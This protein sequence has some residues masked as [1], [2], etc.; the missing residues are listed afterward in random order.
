MN[1][2]FRLRSLLLNDNNFRIGLGGI[3]FAE[4]LVGVPLLCYA[5][6]HGSLVAGVIGAA[7]TVD[8]LASTNVLNKLSG[9]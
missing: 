9:R 3:A 5:V 8:G 7:L 6:L 1:T 4:A 2:L